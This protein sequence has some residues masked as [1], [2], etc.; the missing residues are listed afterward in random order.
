MDDADGLVWVVMQ[1][2]GEMEA[3][4]PEE[5]SREDESGGSEGEGVV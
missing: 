3:V 1:G 2:H 4:V 5:A